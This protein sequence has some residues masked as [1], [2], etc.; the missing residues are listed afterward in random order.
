MLK[1]FI[2]LSL[3][4]T[5]FISAQEIELCSEPIL[6]TKQIVIPGYPNAYNPSLIAYKNGYLLS[7]R[8]TSRFPASLQDHR[9]DASFVG[10][11]R[12]DKKFKLSEK[13]TQLLKIRSHSDRFSLT[14]EDARLLQIGEKIFIFFNDLHPKNPDGFAMYFAEMIEKRGVFLLKESAKLL[15]YPFA[16]EI[17]KNWAPFSCENRLYLIYSDD[18]RIILEVDIETGDCRET[19][20]ITPNW[21]WPFGIIRGGTPAC[22]VNGAFLTFFHS[23]FAANTPKGRAYVMGA[24]LFDK[25]PPF[26]VRSVSFK[27]LGR[28]SDY[29]EKND[30]KII[31]PGGIVIQDQRILVAWG[32]ADKQIQITVF[33]KEKLFHCFD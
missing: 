27:P 16:K 21:N 25:D 18:P 14:A 1:S 31:F 24:Y 2:S 10:L 30:S 13:S 28:L 29:T 20:S 19:P 15:K 9:T 33:D 3:I 7:F 4:S 12:L 5:I 11:A 6:E 22:L 32:K 8:F 23:S 26:A 17:E